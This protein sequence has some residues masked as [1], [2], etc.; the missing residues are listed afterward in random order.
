MS[1][2][3]AKKLR[4]LIGCPI[5]GKRPAGGVNT[6]TEGVPSLGGENI[7][8]EGGVTFDNLNRVPVEFYKSMPKGHLKPL[9]VLINKDGAQT[10]KVGLY[11]GEFTDA[12]INEHLFILRGLNGCLNQRFLYYSTLLPETQIKIARR[13]TGSAQPGLNT[14]FVDAVD[15]QLP[16]DVLEQGKIAEILSTIDEEIEQMEKLIEKYQQIKAGMMHDLFTRGVM[17]DG[18]LR[19][20]REQSP[21]LYKQSPL[22][23]IPKEWDFGCLADFLIGGPQNGYSASE[24]D[25]WS[26]LSALGLGC[27]TPDGFKPIQ[28][29]TVSTESVATRG[30]ILSDGDLLI[31]RSNT[32]ELVGLCG[33]YRDIGNACIYPDLMMRIRPN[34]RTSSDFLEILLLSPLLRLQISSVAVGTSGSMV[35]INSHAVRELKIA[36][37]QKPEQD[38]IVMRIKIERDLINAMKAE[39]QKLRQQKQGLMHD[40]LTG[41]V[42]VNI[43]GTRDKKP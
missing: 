28:I 17:P 3:T 35:K 9:D 23:W 20:S 22:G 32:R 39:Y 25:Y 11:K 19:P 8:A 38:K 26:G 43:D 40:L 16:T 33:I 14:A 12:A 6:E 10:G 31:S 18:Q 42:P 34:Q 5:S 36:V 13:I 7:L 27:L 1:K 2:W 37:P 41:R 21:Q 15:V 24:V 30:A 4:E 29:K